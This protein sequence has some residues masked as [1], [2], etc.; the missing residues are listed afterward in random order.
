MKPLVMNKKEAEKVILEFLDAPQNKRS[1]LWDVVVPYANKY[2]KLYRELVVS[3]SKIRRVK[4][5]K[6]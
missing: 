6:Q 5:E 2:P 3:K 4:D 1:K